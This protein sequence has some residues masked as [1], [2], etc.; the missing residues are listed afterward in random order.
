MHVGV[1]VCVCL[2][3]CVCVQGVAVSLDFIS[4]LSLSSFQPQDTLWPESPGAHI[5]HPFVL[6]VAFILGPPSGSGELRTG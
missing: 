2:C 3:T 6:T 5:S 1:S 4:L